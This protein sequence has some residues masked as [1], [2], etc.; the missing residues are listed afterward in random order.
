MPTQDTGTLLWK[1]SV[2][3]AGETPSDNLGCTQISPQIG[4]TSTPV[5]DRSSSPNGTIYVVA[6]STGKEE[7]AG[8]VAVQA[9]YA[10]S[11]LRESEPFF[12]LLNGWNEV[13]E[14]MLESA[15][16][17]LRDL[18]LNYPAAGIAVATRTHHIRPPLP[19]TTFRAKLHNIRRNRQVRNLW[20]ADVKRAWSWQELTLQAQA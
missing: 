18:E 3:G 6:M 10:L 15:V 8:P 20:Q 9:K 2:L 12:F 4:I 19:G 1:V 7:F 14:A 11:S 5:I 17:A 16:Q 13:S